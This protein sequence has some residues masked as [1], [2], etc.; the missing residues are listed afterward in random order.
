M[1]NKVEGRLK[2]KRG[3]KRRKKVNGVLG[4][5]NRLRSFDTTPTAE[6]M[7]K[8]GGANTQTAR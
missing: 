6:K 8:F 7:N 2:I 4:T 3:K 5:S 1:E